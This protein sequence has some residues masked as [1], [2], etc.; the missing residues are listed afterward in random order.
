MTKQTNY[1]LFYLVG[2]QTTNDLD[3]CETMGI[4]PKYAFT[5]E[6]ND[7]AIKKMYNQN[8]QGY[9]EQGLDATTA[10]GLAGDLAK[11]ARERVN[12][13]MKAK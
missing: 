13:A 6:I 10:A 9:A 11:E 2:D 7:Q 3:V 4:D 5:P 12:K 1:N 8:M